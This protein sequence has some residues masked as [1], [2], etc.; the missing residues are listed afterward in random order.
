MVVVC[1][2]KQHIFTS[3]REPHLLLIG[4]NMWATVNTETQCAGTEILC[5]TEQISS[6]ISICEQTAVVSNLLVLLASNLP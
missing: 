3:P 6:F 1:S 4:C 5:C 2:C